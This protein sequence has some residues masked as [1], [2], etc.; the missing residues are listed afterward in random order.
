MR[1][2]SVFD[3]L[4][5]S[6]FGSGGVS[7]DT[8]AVLKVGDRVVPLKTIRYDEEHDAV[9]FMDEEAQVDEG[10]DPGGR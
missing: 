8:K 5:S 3:F 1:V 6:A 4:G 7:Y 2:H 9:I 10:A